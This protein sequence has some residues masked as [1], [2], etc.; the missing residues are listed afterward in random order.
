[1]LHHEHHVKLARLL[2]AK[3]VVGDPA[4]VFE[5]WMRPEREECL[6]YGGRPD[7]DFRGPQIETPPP[8]GMVFCVFVLPS[9][10]ITDWR[11]ELADS[12]EPDY[13]EN[14]NERFGRILW[15][16]SQSTS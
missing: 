1:L 7:H 15:P 9:G 2:I 13:P 10:K 16:Q 11:W 12:D 3:E 5:D 14:W 6:C 8:P 4:V